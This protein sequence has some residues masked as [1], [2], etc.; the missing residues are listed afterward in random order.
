MGVKKPSIFS[1]DKLKENTVQKGPLSIARTM[2]LAFSY[3][4]VLELHLLKRDVSK[5]LELA[6]QFR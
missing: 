4:W 6:R 2:L 3:R 1:A 5:Y